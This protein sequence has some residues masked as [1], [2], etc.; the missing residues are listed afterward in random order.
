MDSV[1]AFGAKNH[2]YSIASIKQQIG[3]VKNKQYRQYIRKLEYNQLSR[4]GRPMSQLKHLVLH[5]TLE[6]HIYGDCNV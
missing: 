2:T 3:L 1:R 6:T 5:K 4:E